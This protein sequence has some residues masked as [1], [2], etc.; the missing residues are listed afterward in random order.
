MRNF[1]VAVIFIFMSS[2]AVAETC[3]T[4]CHDQC[5]IK[6]K[7]PPMNFIEPT[8]HAKC[9]IAKKAACALKRDIPNIPLTPREQVE[10]FGTQ[11]CAA[12]FQAITGVVIARC[13]NWDGRVD[14]QH[15]IGQAIEVLLRARVATRGDFRG[16]QIRWCPL[17]GAHGMA[18]DRGRI[19]LD[20]SLKNDAFGTA[21]TLAHEVM[22]VR[23]YRRMGT[24]K[25]KCTYSRKYTECRGCQDSRH[26]LEREAY[27][28]E[29]N[30][31]QRI[32]QAMR[33][34]RI[35]RTPNRN[36]SPIHRTP[37]F[38]SGYGMQPCGCWGF[39]P[40]PTVPER[41]CAS[42]MVVIN[43]CPGFCPGGGRPYSY[44]CR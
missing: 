38:P 8:C 18:P 10:R 43:A 30:I 13:S 14:D 35:T 39:S 21:S 22:H 7:F 11:A 3:N 34:G 32:V 40:R 4:D 41:R 27:D 28:F 19:Y 31:Q 37:G 24:D 17:N 26:P 12:P 44:L 36:Q 20:T 16:V 6:T 25:F 42:G 33:S 29:R 2:Q 23:Q 1:F 9:E 15:L 5:R